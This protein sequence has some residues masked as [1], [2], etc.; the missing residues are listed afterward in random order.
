M[1]LHPL[2]HYP[3]G[4]HLKVWLGVKAEA[5]Q[6]SDKNRNE[7]ADYVLKF[8]EENGLS[9]HESLVN[10]IDELVSMDHPLAALKLIDMNLDVWDR[11]DFRG[12]LAEGIAAMITGELPRAELSFAAANQVAPEEPAPYSNMIEILIQDGR[13]EEASTWADAGLNSNPNHYRLWELFLA[14]SRIHAQTEEALAK[15]VF[16]KAQALSS[17]AGTSLAA[18][19]DPEANPSAKVTL[20]AP[21]YNAGERDDEFLIE[22]TGALGASGDMDSIPQILWAAER[23]SSRELPWRLYMHAS[24]AYLALGKFEDF[25][26]MSKKIS[27]LNGVPRDV[28][29]YLDDHL[30]EVLE[31]QSK[32][33]NTVPPEV[34]TLSH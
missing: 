12:A 19:I 34:E 32:T 29:K 21:F 13:Y 3:M 9:D 23:L 31:E 20:L 11:G 28:L 5:E 15:A 25:Q 26:I 4:P 17:W 8:G 7:F 2:A 10:L 27:S 18:E 1:S 24:Q 6:L 22:Y 16:E 14:L 30:K 33:P